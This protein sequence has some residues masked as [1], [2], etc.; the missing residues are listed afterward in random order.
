MPCQG[1]TVSTLEYT[2]SQRENVPRETELSLRIYAVRLQQNI[3]RALA[4]PPPA[5]GKAAVLFHRFFNLYSFTRFDAREVALA[6]LLL[7]TKLEECYVK[8]KDVVVVAMHIEGKE[9]SAKQDPS[10]DPPRGR[11]L[12]E[13]LL[14]YRSA[15]EE[16]EAQVLQLLSFNITQDD[17]YALLLH[18]AKTAQLSH[19]VIDEAWKMLNDLH[20][21]PVCATADVPQLAIAALRQGR[22]RKGASHEA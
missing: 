22:Q 14:G 20:L 17:P 16:A 11:L 10:T 12:G 19:E 15:V 21:S 13:E 2:A 5:T 8:P 6:C 9:G 7:H 1:G 18:Y 3:G 4:I